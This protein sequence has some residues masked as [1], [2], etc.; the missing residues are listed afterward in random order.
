MVHGSPEHSADFWKTF[1]VTNGP[2][3]APS[4]LSEHLA[5]ALRTVIIPDRTRLLDV[6]CG[7]GIIGIH[8]LVEYRARFVTFNDIQPE[9]IDVTRSNIDALIAQHRVRMEQVAFSEG[10]FTDIPKDVVLQHDLIVFNAPQLPES[11][12]SAEM[13]A[14]VKSSGVNSLFRLAGADGLDVTRTFLDW[15]GELSRPPQAVIQLSSFLGLS[16]IEAALERANARY[17]ILSKKEVPLRNIFF[18]AVRSFGAQ[19]IEDRLL[20]K[21]NGSWT[22]QLLVILLSRDAER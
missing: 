20:I 11:K 19:E 18:D 15:Y 10:S 1:L 2:F 12:L 21:R 8:S 22:K 5:I 17:K 16:R 13:L 9:A 4:C 6:G 7:A 3:D 14:T